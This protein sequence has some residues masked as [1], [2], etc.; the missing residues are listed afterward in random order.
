[1]G[2]LTGDIEIPRRIRIIFLVVD[3][4]GSMSCGRMNALNQNVQYLFSYLQE[5]ENNNPDAMYKIAVLEVSTDC[6]WMYETPM[7]LQ[8]FQ[9]KPFEPNG[10][11]NLGM[12]CTELN[13]KLTRNGGFMAAPSGYYAPVVIF[14]SDGLPTDDYNEPLKKLKENNWFKHAITISIGIGTDVDECFLKELVSDEKNIAI[15][16]NSFEMK[17]AFKS[18]AILADQVFAHQDCNLE[19]IINQRS[20]KNNANE[21]SAPIWAISRHRIGT[22]GSGVTSLVTFKDCPLSC[23]FCLNPPSKR[24]QNTKYYLPE[25]LYQELKIDNLYFEATDG[26]VT[27]GGGEPSL[28]DEFIIS[29]RKLCK[30]RITLETSLNVP[31]HKIKRLSRVVDSWI[32]DIKDLN[33]SIYENYTGKSISNLEEGLR[34]LV[35]NRL[36]DKCIIRVPYIP[37]FNT[38]VDREASIKK[39]NEMGFYNIDKFDYIV[40]KQL[41]DKTEATDEFNHAND[42]D[43]YTEGGA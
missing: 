3:K 12:A 38:D 27:F 37:K 4:S 18:I 29:F 34:Y 26:G 32:I 25:E 17:E 42:W 11:S 30:W 43:E 14:L 35:D 2:L 6:H 33:P 28:Y 40:K 5:L 15:V 22:D 7:P 21:V 13:A 20:P 31:L 8:D 9:W 19:E 36:Q 41:E 16:K 10:L 23:T 39:L 1:M 24:N